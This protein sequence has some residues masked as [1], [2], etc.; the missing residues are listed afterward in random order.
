MLPKIASPLAKIASQIPFVKRKPK[1]S[2]EEKIAK[3]KDTYGLTHG[4][5]KRKKNGKKKKK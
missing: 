3:I 4:K 2:T 1:L 5:G